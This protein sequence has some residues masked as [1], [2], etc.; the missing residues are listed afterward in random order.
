MIGVQELRYGT[1]FEENGSLLQVLSYE[2]IKMGRGSANIKVKVKNLRS[3][4]TTEKSFINTARVNDVNVIKRDHQYLYK[5]GDFTYFMNAQTFEQ[6]C[7]PLNV[8]E[9]K[10][11]LKE[12]DTYSISFLDQEPLSVTLPPK[13]VLAVI[14]T[15]PGVKGNSA[16]NVFKDAVLEN[17][18]TTK[19]PPFIRIGDKVRVDTR[20]GA[21]TEKAQ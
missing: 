7:V 19:V 6:V 8:I 11:F 18:L 2:H 17:G 9:G 14:E 4:S 12:G 1:I 21:Y 10:E 16:T 5:D 13:V 20:T 3:G 15:A